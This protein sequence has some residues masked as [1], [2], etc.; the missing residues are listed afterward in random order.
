[1]VS[2]S[3]ADRVLVV[4]PHPDDESLGAGGLLQRMF[5]QRIPVRIVFAT[6][7]ENNPWAQRYWDGRWRIGPDEQVR[8]GRRRRQEALNAICSLGGSPDCANF[9]DLPDLG[10][11]DLLMQ[12]A[13]DLSVP[14]T[15]EIQEW[16]PTLALIPT[17]FDAHPDHSA[18]SVAFARAIDSVGA[19]SIQTWE[20]LVHHPQVPIPRKALKLVLRTEEVERKRRAILCHETQV[21][22]SRRRF[23]SFARTEEAYYPHHPIDLTMD[24]SSPATARLHEG[25]LRLQ[26][27]VSLRQR[28]GSKI[29]IAFRSEGANEHRWMLPVPLRSG[30]VH[31]CDLIRDHRLNEA[32]MQWNGLKLFVDVPV[33]CAPDFE[34]LYAKLSSWTLFF[35]RSGWNR[36][37]VRASRQESFIPPAKMSGLA[38]LL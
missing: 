36:L 37:A 17:I 33:P 14:L 16:E 2:L 35:D 30:K 15:E 29:L 3:K 18:L 23:T 28:F 7:G 4:A 12:G 20:Y 13:R 31:I 22:L 32:I 8:W 34:V 11:T 5:A 26:F 19:S 21:A 6:N 38:T 24:D 9:L 1:M 10:I 27:E 25:V